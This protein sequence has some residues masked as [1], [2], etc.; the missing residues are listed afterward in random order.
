MTKWV[1][2]WIVG[3]IGVFHPNEPLEFR[4]KKQCEQV[5]GQVEAPFR[6]RLVNRRYQHLE[7]RATCIEVPAEG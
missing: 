3:N 1:I 4:D 7:V 6:Y 5:A 2:V